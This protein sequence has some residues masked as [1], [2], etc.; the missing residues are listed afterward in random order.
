MRSISH[1]LITM[2]I[3]VAGCTASKPAQG[4]VA[5]LP[6][7]MPPGAKEVSCAEIESCYDSGKA[8]CGGK[9]HQ[10]SKAGE[11]FP[12]AEVGADQRHRMLVVCGEEK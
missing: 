3:L 10:V 9:W 8:I 2:V 5:A 11:P 12:Y 1:G 4:P 6:S 7:A